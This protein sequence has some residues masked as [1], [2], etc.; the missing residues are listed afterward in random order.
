MTLADLPILVSLVPL[1]AL[2]G[3]CSGS[4]TALLGMTYNDRSR[5]SR[6][7]GPAHR[8]A[9]RLLAH[10]RRLLL[11]IL[12]L[13]MGVNVLY[14]VLAAVLVGRVEGAWWALGLSAG[15][16][17]SIILFGELVPK[18]V[19]SAHRVWVCSWLAAPL[20]VAIGLVTPVRVVIEHLAVA[21]MTRLIAPQAHRGSRT[22]T[23]EELAAL[24]EAGVSA[25]AV[26]ATEHR[27]LAEVVE[28]GARRVR[29]VMIP[30]VDVPWVDVERGFAGVA[31]LRG[32]R[33][34]YVPACR[35]TA[36][37]G[38]LD[39]EV[40]GMLDVVSYLSSRTAGGGVGGADPPMAGHLHPPVYVPES[41]RLDHLLE[42]LRESRADSAL[43]VDEHGAVTGLA[44]LSML[45]EELITPPGE[46]SEEDDLRVQ[47]LGP[48]R[49][50]APG[51]LSVRN[52]AEFVGV[53]GAADRRVSTLAGLVLLHLGRVPREGDVVEVSN[54]RLEV[55]KM[56]GPVIQRI[57]VSTADAAHPGEGGD[58]LA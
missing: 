32:G 56:R 50:L 1:L 7:S 15:T 2:S 53:P 6:R 8:A 29:E 55:A 13:N 18:L 48:G 31:E 47:V 24:L 40:V 4:E 35:A 33:R 45:I 43:C 16:L 26:S 20:E 39:G 37:G 19:A 42:R 27:L 21:P 3:L 44:D 41:A 23:G 9:L 5:L 14:F 54:V 34:R 49:W 22:V 28:L 11:S 36:R 57:V 52:W 17:L 58:D 10:P 51:R 25:G 12:I 30:R 46:L 38:G